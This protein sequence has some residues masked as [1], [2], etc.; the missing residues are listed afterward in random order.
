MMCPLRNKLILI[1]LLLYTYMHA[2]VD[3]YL[4]APPEDI[5]TIYKAP[6]PSAP[7]Y[8][9]ITQ[10]SQI[11]PIPQNLV[12]QQ[13]NA[14]H[15]V[16]EQSA[17]LNNATLYGVTTV[18]PYVSDVATIGV[19]DGGQYSLTQL[20]GVVQVSRAPTG[21][22]DVT[23]KAYVDAH[24]A[25]LIVKD[26]A[27]VISTNSADMSVSPPQGTATIDGVVVGSTPTSNERV[28]LTA[29]TALPNGAKD[30]GLW[31]ANSGVWTRPAD[32]APGSDAAGSYVYIL[33]G[34]TFFGST[35]QEPKL[36]SI[37]YFVA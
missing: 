8:P 2:S 32:Y 35:S 10:T 22:L 13:I 16:A 20:N 30:N 5:D 21:N 11:T 36:V 6:R 23:N 29:Q 28:V 17:L 3:E 14:H 34:G 27:V 12:T 25:G 24:S 4:N 7:L 19:E 18:S 1:F 15:I 26:P 9:N 33:P 31:L 37:I